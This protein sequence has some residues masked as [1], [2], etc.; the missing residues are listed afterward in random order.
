MAAAKIREQAL[1]EG[2]LRE[3]AAAAVAAA[4]AA[5]KIAADKAKV[6][7][8]GTESRDTGSTILSSTS[9]TGDGEILNSSSIPQDTTTSCVIEQEHR[10]QQGH[11]LAVGG[12]M[13]QWG[14]SLETQLRKL[15]SLE[16]ARRESTASSMDDR[17]AAAVLLLEAVLETFTDA[18]RFPC[19]RRPDAAVLVAATEDAYVSPQSVLDLHAHLPGSEVRWVPGGHVS[20]FILHQP[21]F[22]TAI[23]DSLDKLNFGP[24]LTS[25]ENPKG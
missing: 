3:A 8:T 13:S 14:S 25:S 24:Q 19:P 6:I 22:R 2:N 9:T 23:V 10:A 4:Q 21:T 17:H 5:A 1:F 12:W 20:S 7:T 18:T 15:R 16:N 11:W